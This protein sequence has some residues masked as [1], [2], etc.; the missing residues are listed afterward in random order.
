V[1]LHIFRHVEAQQVDSQ[2]FGEPLGD[3]RLADAGGA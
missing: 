1:P 3:F 2:H